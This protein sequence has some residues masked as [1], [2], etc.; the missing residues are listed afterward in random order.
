MTTEAA[1]GSCSEND[2]P[3]SGH[4]LKVSVCVCVCVCVCMC[5]CERESKA[6]LLAKLSI[7]PELQPFSEYI[8][9][10][11]TVSVNSQFLHCKK[12]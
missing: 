1:I 10:A 4:S 9:M 11:A 12:L 5:V 2:F 8:W 3:E 6:K 7:K